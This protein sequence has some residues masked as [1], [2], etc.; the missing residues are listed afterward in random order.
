[1][2]AVASEAFTRAAIARISKVS[3]R[4]KKEEP[5][6]VTRINVRRSLN[7]L[8]PVR[9]C[10]RAHTHKY[11]NALAFVRSLTDKRAS[12][13]MASLKDCALFL[14]ARAR[15]CVCVCGSYRA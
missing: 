15:A 5:I 10:V 14:R 4:R 3:A 1:M 13:L 6:A 12:R 2:E 7:L 8:S 11:S 9:G